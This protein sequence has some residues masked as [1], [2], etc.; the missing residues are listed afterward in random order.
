MLK[1]M[2]MEESENKAAYLEIRLS[3]DITVDILLRKIGKRQKEYYHTMTC[4][5]IFVPDDTLF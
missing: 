2:K 3:D 4:D 5:M 1:I